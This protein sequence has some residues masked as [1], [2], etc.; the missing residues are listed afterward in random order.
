MY[1]PFG[2]LFHIFQRPGQPRR[3]V[4]QAGQRRRPAGGAAGAAAT[5]FASAQQVAD[6]KAVLPQVGFDYDTADGG[7]YQD[8]CPRCRRAQVTLAQSARVGGFG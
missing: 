3:G 1:I 4:L 8:T 2:K 7:S 6:L 5:A